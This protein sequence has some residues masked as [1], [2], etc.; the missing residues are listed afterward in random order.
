MTRAFR[1]GFGVALLGALAVHV[2]AAGRPAAVGSWRSAAPMVEA[3]QELYPE[4]LNGRIYVAGGILNPNTRYSDAF[5]VYD[6]ARDRWTALAPLPAARHHITLSAVGGRIYGIGGFSGGFPDWRA[7]RT[8]WIYDPARN[9][10]TRGV[11]MPGPRAEGVA[12]VVDGKIYWIGGRV[13]RTPRSAHFNDHQDTNRNEMY[14]PATRRW[15][16]RAPAPT[17]RNSAA[18]GVIDGKIYVVGGRRFI[19]STDGTTRMRNFTNLEVYDPETNRWTTRAPMPQGQGG[20]GA[21]VSDGRLHVCGGEQWLP[22]Q[23]VLAECWTYAPAADTWR[24]LPSLRI[25]RH[26]IGMA[27]VGRNLHVFGGATRPG[28][29]FATAVHEVLQLR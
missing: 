10:W 19:R 9:R 20:L 25:P 24:P 27:A 12:A 15:S 16:V 29:N 1:L 7:E 13:P 6:P 3:R 22:S 14:D 11:D 4:V 8:M 18:V 26:G 5:E 21:A 2:G 23:A 17:A 28:G